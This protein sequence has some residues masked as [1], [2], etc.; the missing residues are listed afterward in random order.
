MSCRIGLPAPVP[1]TGQRPCFL[2]NSLILGLETHHEQRLEA[3]ANVVGRGAT[4]FDVS[5]QVFNHQTLDRH[6]ARMAVAETLAHL[7]HLVDRN[8]LQRRDDEAWWYEPA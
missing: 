5:R 2:T 7:D 4:V 3:M 8:R 1:S 6:Q